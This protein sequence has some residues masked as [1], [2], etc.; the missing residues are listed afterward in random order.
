MFKLIK[1]LYYGKSCGKRPNK[2]RKQMCGGEK[3]LIDVTLIKGMFDNYG[4]RYTEKSLSDK[5]SNIPDY[6][7][8]W[9]ELMGN[10]IKF[11]VSEHGVASV[12]LLSQQELIEEYLDINNSIIIENNC[13]V[14]AHGP[15]GDLICV[16]ES[17]GK[18]VFVFHD[19]LWESETDDFSDISIK[20][21]LGLEDYLEKVITG[22]DY[23]ADGYDAEK[24]TRL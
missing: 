3:R 10:S 13:H 9:A 21:D 18:L 6:L 14:I 22:A 8:R 2:K 4:V 1:Q 17:D 19:D 11:D 16:D 15:N 7:A 20:I 23:P 12:Y 24:Y 5:E